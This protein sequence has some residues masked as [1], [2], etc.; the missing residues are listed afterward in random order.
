MLQRNLLYTAVTRAKRQVWL[1]GER[2]AIQRAIDNNK[3][4]RRNTLL[5]QAISGALAARKASRPKEEPHE[6]SADSRDL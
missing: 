4:T 3:V 1:L 5:A 2:S 6:P